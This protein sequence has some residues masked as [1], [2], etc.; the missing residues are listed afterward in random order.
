M[1]VAN[2][3]HAARIFKNGWDSKTNLAA[4][5]LTPWRT[6]PSMSRA[7]K[8]KLAPCPAVANIATLKFSLSLYGTR[9]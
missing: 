3:E 2:R 9:L 5:L 1:V 6:P 7:L 4:L 8:K